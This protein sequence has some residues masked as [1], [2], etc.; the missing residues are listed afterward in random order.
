MFSLTPTERLLLS[1]SVALGVVA[2]GVGYLLP[3]AGTSIL[4]D[5]MV[6]MS[7]AGSAISLAL[8]G[9]RVTS[10]AN[11]KS[12]GARSVQRLGLAAS[13]ARDAAHRLREHA[14]NDPALI[15]IAAQLD[16]LAEEAEVSIGDL[17]MMSGSKISLDPLV[18]TAMRGIEAAVD[19]ALPGESTQVKSKVLSAIAEPLKK[20]EADVKQAAVALR[21]A[22]HTCPQCGTTLST[23]IG[24]SAGSTVHATCV[25][26]QSQMTVHRMPDGSLSSRVIVPKLKIDC[27]SCATP[28]AVRV[29]PEDPDVVVRNCFECDERIYVDVVKGE[30]RSSEKR[31]PLQ[32]NYLVQGDK[33]LITCPSCLNEIRASYNPAFNPLKAS[34]ARCT[35][36]IHA[37]AA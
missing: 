17:E 11:V 36:L 27:P 22:A 25:Q 33:A 34:C 5:V 16:N 37:T 21:A 12:V 32:A 18:Q 13:H 9:A 26:C 20:L 3:S 30:V 6:L 24:E 35:N 4:K 1:L 10:S 23:V 7:G 8:A 29:R 15:L 2:I 14:K 31:P 19:Q 28:I